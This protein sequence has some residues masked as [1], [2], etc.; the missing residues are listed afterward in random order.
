M[1]DHG[2]SPCIH[3]AVDDDQCGECLIG[4]HFPAGC[5][6]SRRGAIGCRAYEPMGQPLPHF[7]ALRILQRWRA[8]RA[9]YTQAANG[10]SP[11]S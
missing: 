7:E 5:E 6:V 2:Q 9:H 11:G 1:D 4:R 8:M 10:I 3:L